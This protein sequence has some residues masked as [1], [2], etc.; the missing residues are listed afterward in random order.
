MAQQKAAEGAAKIKNSPGTRLAR[1]WAK[2][3]PHLARRI[4]LLLLAAV[5]LGLM[6][7]GLS[8]ISAPFVRAGISVLILAVILAL[9]AS[10]GLG[11][12][13]RDAAAGRRAARME[14]EGKTLLPEEDAA[15]WHPLKAAAALL[16]VFAVPL[17]LALFI[18]LTAEPYRYTLQDLPTWLTATYGA[19]EDV[20]APL[21]AYT[22]QA[23]PDARILI[24]IVVRLMEMTFVGFFPDPQKS[25]LLLDRLAPVFLL[26]YPI[27][28]FAAYCLGPRRQAALEKRERKAVRAA[29]RRQGRKKLAD[30]LVRGGGEVHYGQRT[31]AQRGKD[32]RLV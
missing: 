23:A 26:A 3:V 1:A 14:A 27:A 29:V 25:A 9:F 31:D 13:M 24:R 17:L 19:R 18:A 7:S 15:C 6:F 20:M 32:R 10:E 30:E 4:A 21:G 16:L 2:D 22:E 28:Y 12:G 5:V 11:A 8:A